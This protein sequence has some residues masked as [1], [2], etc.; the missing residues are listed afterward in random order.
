MLPIIVPK[1]FSG[2]FFWF[3]PHG[4]PWVAGI[5]RPEGV[6]VFAQAKR[7]Q[8]DSSR[9]YVEICSVEVILHIQ[10][11]FR[12]FSKLKTPTTWVPGSCGGP[13]ASRGYCLPGRSKRRGHVS[14]EIWKLRT[15][16]GGNVRRRLPVQFLAT[17][18]SDSSLSLK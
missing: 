16:L 15:F 4:C 8:Q 12:P 10:H 6:L 18:H 17:V 1:E 14:R 13:C 3:L 11:S 7:E 9:F 5:I 2:Q